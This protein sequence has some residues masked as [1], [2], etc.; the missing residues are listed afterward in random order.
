MLMD[1]TGNQS[2]KAKEAL[3]I[4]AMWRKV[5]SDWIKVN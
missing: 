2:A 1:H 4:L 3:R 5:C